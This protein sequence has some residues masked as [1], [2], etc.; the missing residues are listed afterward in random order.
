MTS[1]GDA[2]AKADDSLP[3][4]ISALRDGACFDHPTDTIVVLQTH[5]SYVLLTGTYAY[6]IKKAVSLPFSTSAL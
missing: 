4:L 6:K 3:P 5:I 2:R 1:D